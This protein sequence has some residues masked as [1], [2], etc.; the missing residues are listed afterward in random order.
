MT[1]KPFEFKV[2][3]GEPLTIE[4]AVFQALGAASTCWESMEGTGVF[5]D[6]YAKAIGEAL[7]AEIRKRTVV[8]VWEV[9]PGKFAWA[10]DVE[11]GQFRVI[12]S[13]PYESAEEAEKSARVHH[14]DL[15]IE[16]GLP[17]AILVLNE[18]H[19][20]EQRLAEARA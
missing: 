9:T 8:A 14:P 19:R 7:L 16:R 2:Q 13:A 5:D 20:A 3:E 18:R 17:H 6:Q 12:G 15:T 1:D 11:G 10:L 4:T